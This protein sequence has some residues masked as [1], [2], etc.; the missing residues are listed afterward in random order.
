MLA[1]PANR[2]VITKIKAAITAGIRPT[3]LIF[4]EQ[5]TD[6]WIPFD[7]KLLEAYQILQDELCPKC[8]HPVWLCRSTSQNV[9][10]KVGTAYCAGERAL[11][12]HEA[13]QMTSSERRKIDKKERAGWGR[14]YYVRP[15]VPANVEG[16]LPG[17]REYYEELSRSRIG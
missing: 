16:D 10:F 14:F 9:E 3:A 12:E 1:E 8:G 4:H 11:K 5:P 7:F 15:D 13:A 17:R 2:H 6:P